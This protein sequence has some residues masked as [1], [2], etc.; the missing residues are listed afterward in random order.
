MI[1]LVND[2]PL[3]DCSSDDLCDEL[4]AGRKL[5]KLYESGEIACAPDWE[6]LNAIK[7][8][9]KIR[10]AIEAANHF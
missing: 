4:R 1:Y 2:L 6:K 8:E 10:E 9:L 7:H 5:Q 3:A